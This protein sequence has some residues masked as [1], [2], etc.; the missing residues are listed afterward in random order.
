MTKVSQLMN[1]SLPLLPPD[2]PIV[3]GVEALAA[4]AVSSLPVVTPDGRFVGLLRERDVMPIL[5]GWSVHDRVVGDFMCRRVVTFSPDDPVLEVCDCIFHG[6]VTECPVVDASRLYVGML[7][8]RAL[9]A[10]AA[11]LRSAVGRSDAARLTAVGE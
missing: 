10:L 4:A 9:V 1:T 7:L 2:L 8:P 3:H 11:R 6:A 5:L